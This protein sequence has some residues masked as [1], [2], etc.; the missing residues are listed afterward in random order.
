MLRLPYLL[1]GVGNPG[2]EPRRLFQ[3]RTD[4]LF[5]EVA[6]ERSDFLVAHV[7]AS[8]RLEGLH[9]GAGD[10]RAVEQVSVGAVPE[11]DIVRPVLVA[12]VRTAADVDELCGHLRVETQRIERRVAGRCDD[13]L[14]GTGDGA[15]DLVGAGRHLGAH[16]RA[17][18][19]R[20]VD[21]ADGAGDP[22]LCMQAPVRVGSIASACD[23]GEVG[24][25]AVLPSR[26]GRE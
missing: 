21:A 23:V 5:R 2:G 11:L 22:S 26:D 15:H 4:L 13:P 19:R 25:S 14:V 3:E 24:G 17:A 9:D 18:L 1:R 16:E 6:R 7:L 12:L 8:E 20:V 10:L